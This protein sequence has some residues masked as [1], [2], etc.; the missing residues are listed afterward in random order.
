[1]I[2]D[3]ELAAVRA[4]VGTAAPP[5]DLDLDD[6]WGRLASVEAVALEVI[7]TRLAALRSR[8]TIFTVEGDYTENWT[9]TIKALTDQEAS[10]A[11][12]A[13]P[14]VPGASGGALRV[15]SMRRAGPS[16]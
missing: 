7:R 1:M 13:A 10:L 4:H 11:A 5:S 9:G 12:A 3:A 15:L 16:R 8:P 14:T 2:P 6:A